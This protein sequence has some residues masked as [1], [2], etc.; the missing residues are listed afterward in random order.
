MHVE[1]GGKGGKGEKANVAQM[2]DRLDTLTTWITSE[3]KW[4]STADPFSLYM[5]ALLVDA[6]RTGTAISLLAR[7]GYAREAFK[8][9]RSVTESTIVTFWA[10][11]GARSHA[12]AGLR[13]TEHDVFTRIIWQERL[14]TQKDASNRANWSR[15]A[16]L[17]ADNRERLTALYGK[18]GEYA[19]W[20][21][22]VTKKENGKWKATTHRNTRTLVAALRDVPELREGLWSELGWPVVDRLQYLLDVPQRFAD[23]LHHGA[24]LGLSTIMTGEAGA[25][26]IDRDPSDNWAPQAAAGL[27]HCLALL[28]TLMTVKY[29]PDLDGQR[30]TVIDYAAFAALIKPVST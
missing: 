30:R 24:P 6:A 28:A 8:L 13:V 21:N 26:Q 25:V 12:W 10:M 29:R 18:R 7:E 9:A 11:Y 4:T 15:L 17:D 23:H 20:A 19:W 16:D 5:E 2:L 22:D 3:L 14:P 1:K 27:Y